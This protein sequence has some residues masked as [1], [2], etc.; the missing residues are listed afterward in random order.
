MKIKT[1]SPSPI[2]LLL[3]FIRRP[4]FTILLILLSYP[5]ASLLLG[6]KREFRQGMLTAYVDLQNAF[7][8]VH[9]DAIWNLLCL[10]GIPAVIIGLLSGLY[11]GTESAVKYRRGEGG[12]RVQ[13]LSCAYGS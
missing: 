11:S 8:S 13:L 1:V 5:S 7:D 10:R 4:T 3:S 2:S 12:G 9:P 6:R